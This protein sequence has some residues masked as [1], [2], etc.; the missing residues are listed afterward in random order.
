MANT[1][2]G[3][4]WSRRAAYHTV[5]TDNEE[6]FNLGMRDS[7]I[8]A[9]FYSDKHND[10]FSR[11]VFN[12]LQEMEENEE[13]GNGIILATKPLVA[14][15]YTYK[16]YD[17]DAGVYVDGEINTEEWVRDDLPASNV[18]NVLESLLVYWEAKNLGRF[19][20]GRDFEEYGPHEDKLKEILTAPNKCVV[21]VVPQP[22]IVGDDLPD[23]KQYVYFLER[24]SSQQ[25][26]VD[27]NR[28]IINGDGLRVVDVP[29]R[30]TGGTYSYQKTSDGALDGNIGLYYKTPDGTIKPEDKV[31]GK[32][33]LSYDQNSQ[34]WGVQNQILAQLKTPLDSAQ[35]PAIDVTN[36]VA[37]NRN[38]FYEQGGDSFI[39]QFTTAK[40]IVLSKEQNNPHMFGPS[41]IDP[42][43]DGLESGTVEEIR[44]VN[45]TNRSYSANTI[46]MCH[47]IDNEWIATDFGDDPGGDVGETTLTI[48]RWHF[49]QF[50]SNSDTHFSS[51]FSDVEEPRKALTPEGL[52]LSTRFRSMAWIKNNVQFQDSVDAEELINNNTPLLDPYADREVLTHTPIQM[53]S[54]DSLGPELGGMSTHSY[55]GRINPYMNEQ[56]DMGGA[57]EYYSQISPYF[58]PLFPDG[59]KTKDYGRITSS[60][61]IYALSGTAGSIEN[62]GDFITGGASIADSFNNVANA[63]S[64]NPSYHGMFANIDS[65]VKN[66]PADVGIMGSWGDHSSPIVDQVQQYRSLTLGVLP[67]MLFDKCEVK[68]MSAN[69]DTYTDALAMEPVNPKKVTF[70]P[71]T[72][73]MA[74]S[75]D[76]NSPSTA[77]RYDRNWIAIRDQIYGGQGDGGAGVVDVSIFGNTFLQTETRGSS[78]FGARGN[79]WEGD[80]TTVSIYG[81][82]VG[83]TLRNA[84]MYDCY[85]NKKAYSEPINTNL[86][87]FYEDDVS[88]IGGNLLGVIT[89]RNVVAK[90]RG[91]TVNI[92]AACSYGVVGDSIGGFAG[93]ANL[94][95]VM[96]VAFGSQSPGMSQRMIPGW[97]STDND[98]V[99]SFGTT[100]LHVKVYDYWPE[101][102]T[103]YD[104]VN[105]AVHHTV[106]GKIGS[107]P[108]EIEG[109]TKVSFFGTENATANYVDIQDSIEPGEDTDSKW[110]SGEYHRFTYD[111]NTTRE[112]LGNEWFNS[113]AWSS[114][115][116]NTVDYRVPTFS[117]SDPNYVD[118]ATVESNHVF[119]AF[120][121]FRPYSKWNICTANRGMPLSGV[122]KDYAY[123]FFTRET[124]LSFFDATIEETGEGYEVG[125]EIEA[126]FGS[127]LKITDVNETGGVTMVGFAMITDETTGV[128]YPARGTGFLPANIGP[129]GYSLRLSGG[130][131]IT[132]N[133]GIVYDIPRTLYGPKEHVPKSKL[134]VGSGDGR[135]VIWNVKST[136][137]SLPSNVD[138]PFAGL[139]EFF[140]YFHNDI[141]HTYFQQKTSLAGVQPPN[142]QFIT[143]DIS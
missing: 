129:D 14:P 139:Y 1:F 104:A 58:G 29:S 107:R 51:P 132:V 36:D 131:V 40:A 118:G 38:S 72:A 135:Q 11:R 82:A 114:Y 26:A 67:G 17:R 110:E 52:A 25:P 93:N 142:I 90:N 102:A 126:A 18:G 60:E 45:R 80:P 128:R 124:G 117:L 125:Q 13:H 109:V 22:R 15:T 50:V 98:D 7:N 8:F 6:Y 69:N 9:W 88:G 3:N 28:F 143:I 127:I 37:P 77:D 133:K 70:M 111:D 63:F 16:Y 108:E 57:L 106:P 123:I 35:V 79:L 91:G 62:V 21:G 136:S 61:G 74:G 31:S 56:G 120:T 76:T 99:D 41:F 122:D 33:R 138:S 89:A 140:Y 55:L 2:K 44:V 10:E 95:I 105:F 73:E 19:E 47:L 137:I 78:A 112:S 87:P 92:E 94:S 12:G 24:P 101:P 27:N 68:L 116:T 115:I 141:S 43:V 49:D 42:C 86:V 121:G 113:E 119:N 30:P 100:A 48:G 32:V 23:L 53:T 75:M 34:T 130:A 84:I 39:G 66:L 81:E 85:L 54:F 64:P 46:V 96:G 83:S 4:Y 5:F 65:N 20:D 97:G 103:F 71:M 134:S 59:F